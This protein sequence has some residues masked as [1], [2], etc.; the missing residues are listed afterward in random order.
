MNAG[1]SAG[2]NF[3]GNQPERTALFRLPE[4]EGTP[5]ADHGFF[6]TAQQEGFCAKTDAKLFQRLIAEMTGAPAPQRFEDPE[7]Q[8]VPA[9]GLRIIRK[10][11]GGADA[12]SFPDQPEPAR[13]M[14]TV[15]VSA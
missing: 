7:I 6:F 4:A 11:Q 3:R 13:K 9:S 15:S 14:G 10:D 2:K 12:F 8:N 5:E 1:E